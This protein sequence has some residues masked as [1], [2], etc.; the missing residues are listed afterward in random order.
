MSEKRTA[1]R[2]ETLEL[3]RETLQDLTEQEVEQ[4]RGG[5]MTLPTERFSCRAEECVTL[6][7]SCNPMECQH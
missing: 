1:P 2:S 7:V 5:R 6:R 3:N 4:A